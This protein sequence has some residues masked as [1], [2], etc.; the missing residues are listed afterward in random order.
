MIRFANDTDI[1]TVRRLWESCFPDEGGFNAYFFRKL[2]VPSR[3]LLSTEGGTLC[4]MVQM[5]PCSLRTPGGV[6][7]A[8]YIYGACTAPESRRKGHMSR[9]LEESFQLDRLEG[10]AASV[11]IPAE[12]WLFDFYR[13]FGYEPFFYSSRRQ[14]C[15]TERG[16]LPRRLTAADIPRL[17]ARYEALDTS[18]LPQR[19]DAYWAAQM[20]MFDTLGRGVYGWFDGDTLTAYAFCWADT[21]QEAIG[22]TPPQEQGLLQILERDTLVYTTF[23]RDVPVGCC[24][25]YQNR[26][27]D[28]G[29]MNLM[30]N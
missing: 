13:P 11:L 10:R 30:W 29:Y 28:V 3:T 15:R 26:P 4:A 9:L 17:R 5:L 6:V 27:A 12:P 24:K 20:N 16:V 25:W 8:T 22:L 23:G 19:L 7:T 21:A 1:P 14:L 18:C 2:Y